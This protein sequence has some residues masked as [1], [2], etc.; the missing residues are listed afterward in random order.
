[1]Y[2]GFAVMVVT[3]RPLAGFNM[4]QEPVDSHQRRRSANHPLIAEKWQR[5]LSS[6][7]GWRTAGT[8]P[9]GRPRMLLAPVQPALCRYEIPVMDSRPGLRT[10][11]PSSGTG[12][13]RS[14]T[15][16]LPPDPLLECAGWTR[17][18]FGI[19]ESDVDY[20]VTIIETEGFV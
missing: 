18:A 1:M 10:T 8:T 12:T 13:G 7:S 9:D 4:T 16:T 20:P 2:D 17:R 11:S 3:M 15:R 6:A 14:N 19:R 5:D